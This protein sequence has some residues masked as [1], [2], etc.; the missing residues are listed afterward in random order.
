A[1]RRHPHRQQPAGRRQRRGRGRH[2]RRADQIRDAQGGRHAL[3][4]PLP[5]HADAIPGQ[6]RLRAP[7]PVRGRR[8]DRR[9]GGEHAPHHTGGRP[10]RAARGRAEDGGRRRRRREDHRRAL[11]Q[12][13]QALPARPEPHGPAADHAGADP[14]LLRALQGP[15]ARQVGE[16][17]RLGRR[18]R[19]PALHQGSDRAGQ[20]EGL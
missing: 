18:G 12:A 11:A 6:L 17:D 3:R 5:A 15:G 13:H 14:P 20:G 7:Y 9:A 4:G 19:S 1:P 8:P 16:G 2:R 10:Q